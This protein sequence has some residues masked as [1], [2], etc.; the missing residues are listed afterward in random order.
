MTLRKQKPMPPEPP[1]RS[2]QASHSDLKPVL[3]Q[4]PE[5][6]VTEQRRF[7]QPKRSATLTGLQVAALRPTAPASAL[8][9]ATVRVPTPPDGIK[10][11]DA[12]APALEPSLPPPS[13]TAD[14]ATIEAVR[15]RAETA[16]AELA[17]L[18]RQGRVRAETASPASFPPAVA[19]PVTPV[20]VV[21]H[22]GV[23]TET[24][25]AYRR[26]VTKLML[27]VAGLLVAVAAPCALWLTNAAMQAER[28][29]RR[30]Q[31]QAT[32]AVK[33]SEIAKVQTRGNDKEI[34]DLKLQLAAERSYNR[35]VLRRMGVQIPK[36]PGDPDPPELKT[37]TPLA[38]PGKIS[39]A[40]VLVVTTPPP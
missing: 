34:D 5:G 9:R 25:E 40:P 17:E 22:Q 28:D 12:L 16:E 39:G 21:V 10:V 18:K 15:R 7:D 24:L 37:E 33:T 36:R 6:S 11:T 31:V 2:R 32:E 1:K 19:P 27:A 29:T 8:A 20:P 35:E 3:D 13:Q 4:T 38:K 26:A 30:T 14:G 23:S